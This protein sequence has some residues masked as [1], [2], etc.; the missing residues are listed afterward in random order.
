MNNGFSETLS[1]KKYGEYLQQQQQGLIQPEVSHPL[2][3]QR[4]A[5]LEQQVL[6]IIEVLEVIVEQRRFNN[7]IQV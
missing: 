4:I 1:S 2:T 5:R 6:A 3:L 7:G